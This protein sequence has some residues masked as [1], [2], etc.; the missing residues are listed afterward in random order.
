M[1]LAADEVVWGWYE[2][3]VVGVKG[4]VFELRWLLWPDL[5]AIVRRGEHLAVMPVAALDLLRQ[6]VAG[7][8]LTDHS[9]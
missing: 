3:E 5:P 9:A 7:R 8:W 1:V 2:A 6:Q 4:D